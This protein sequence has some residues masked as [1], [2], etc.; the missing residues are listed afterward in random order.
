MLPESQKTDQ[1]KVSSPTISHK[2]KKYIL[3]LSILFILIIVNEVIKRISIRKVDDKTQVLISKTPIKNVNSTPIIIKPGY[4]Y[5]KSLKINI[6]VPEG[7]NGNETLGI[8]TLKKDKVKGEIRISKTSTQY[9]SLDDAIKNTK[10]KAIFNARKSNMSNEN[11]IDG[12]SFFVDDPVS[13]QE[14]YFFYIN[15]NI[16]NFFT[17]DIDLLF[18]LHELAFRFKYSEQAVTPAVKKVY[19]F[20]KIM[21]EDFP[22]YE[23][24]EFGFSIGYPL[25]SEQSDLST[26]SIKDR[27]GSE[28]EEAYIGGNRFDLIAQPPGAYEYY[29]GLIVDVIY[30]DN[31]RKKNLTQFVKQFIDYDPEYGTG[32]KSDGDVNINGNIGKKLTYCCYAGG[33]SMYFFL[34]KSN[35]YIIGIYRTPFGPDREKYDQVAEKM[36]KSFKID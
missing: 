34:T 20:N 25:E 13:P 2:Y 30:F 15:H 17:D 29:D 19:D 6:Y 18:E 9:D 28:T 31:L 12:K 11:G 16:Y 35:K 1:D 26:Q 4:Y 24:K 3:I 5:S 14:G 33:S 10:N 7:F 36:V 32:T 22:T 21:T 8:I 23:N 27:H